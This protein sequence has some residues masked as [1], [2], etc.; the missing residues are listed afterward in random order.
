MTVEKSAGCTE[1]NNAS[2]SSLQT[3]TDAPECSSYRPWDRIA[4]RQSIQHCLSEC[5]ESELITHGLTFFG[6]HLLFLFFPFPNS[7]P[8]PQG[9]NHLPSKY[10]Q[11]ISCLRLCFWENLNQLVAT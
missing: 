10:M 5:N 1:R 2:T 9:Y 8:Q 4:L 3:M 7:C 6:K 11:L